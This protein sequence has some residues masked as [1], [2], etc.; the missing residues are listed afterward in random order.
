MILNEDPKGK[1]WKQKYFR[2][3]DNFLH[4]EFQE[5]Q[6]VP[7]LFQNGYYHQK[8]IGKSKHNMLV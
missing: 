8:S 5:S 7:G 6:E 3:L 4:H 2:E 1:K